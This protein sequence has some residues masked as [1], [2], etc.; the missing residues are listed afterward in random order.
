MVCP[1]ALADA[2]ADEKRISDRGSPGLD[3]LALA[4]LITSGRYDRHL[5]RMRTVYSGRR[6][7]LVDA[8]ATHAPHVRLTGL[9]AGFHAVAHLPESVDETA[10]VAA[11]ADRGVGLHGMSRYR[12][13]RSTTPPRLVLGFGN[14]SERAIQAGVAAIDDLLRP[15]SG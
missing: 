8:L 10:V 5:R 3:Q 12:A 1:P 15:G 11:A 13:D 7:V 14:L 2:V 9:A 4:T 6:A